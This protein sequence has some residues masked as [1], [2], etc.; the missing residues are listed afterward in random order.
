LVK[1]LREFNGAPVEAVQ[2]DELLD[3]LL[4]T[5]RADFEHGETYE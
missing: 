2:N 1:K 3:L 5:I 4:P